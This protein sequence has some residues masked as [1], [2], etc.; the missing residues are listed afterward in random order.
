MQSF[1][2][3]QRQIICHE[4]LL[5]SLKRRIRPQLDQKSAKGPLNPAVTCFV[6][7]RTH[8]DMSSKDW[9]ALTLQMQL[10]WPFSTTDFSYYL[11]IPSV[12]LPDFWHYMNG[13]KLCYQQE[14]SYSGLGVPRW[15]KKGKEPNHQKCGISQ[16]PLKLWAKSE[17]L[18]P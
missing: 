17:C 6:W 11:Q 9:V 3:D 16:K 15:L 12:D 13:S 8:I 5:E 7:P 1:I 10:V 18:L 14:H 2:W 4:V